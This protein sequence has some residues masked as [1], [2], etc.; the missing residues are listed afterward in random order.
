MDVSVMHMAGA[1]VLILRICKTDFCAHW[2]SNRDRMALEKREWSHRWWEKLDHCSWD[3]VPEPVVLLCPHHCISPGTRICLPWGQEKI[4]I[5]GWFSC[6]DLIKTSK[7]PLNRLVPP[8]INHCPHDFKLGILTASLLKPTSRTH[9]CHLNS[10]CLPS[11]RWPTAW[12]FSLISKKQRGLVI[13]VCHSHTKQLISE[14]I[15]TNP[16]AP[17]WFECSLENER[18]LHNLSL[19]L[20][21]LFPQHLGRHE[22]H[23]PLPAHGTY[24]HV[25][26]W[27]LY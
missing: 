23:P 9:S 24:G 25:E 7:Q 20:C 3:C 27:I 2:A 5:S 8:R 4:Y 19:S 15:L 17:S 1:C 21:L 10:A 16:G 13:G 26:R 18:T 14:W 11:I 12:C 6:S 22:F